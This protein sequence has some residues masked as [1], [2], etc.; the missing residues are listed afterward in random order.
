MD[1]RE[2]DIL[3]AMIDQ[4]NLRV[5]QN[6]AMGVP[7]PRKRAS[8]GKTRNLLSNPVSAAILAK[9]KRPS[10]Q[11]KTGIRGLT[12]NES[13]KRWVV[14]WTETETRKRKLRVF[15]DSNP[16]CGGTKEG[17][18]KAAIEFLNP[19]LPPPPPQITLQRPTK[20]LNIFGLPHPKTPQE[21]RVQSDMFSGVIK[22]LMDKAS[23]PQKVS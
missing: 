13:R 5:K 3:M 7:T 2:A 9:I 8:R 18:Y 16:G 10:S 4:H 11:S 6:A 15:S 17:A 19:P 22:E 14:R 20:E 21:L 12:R 23:A 1:D